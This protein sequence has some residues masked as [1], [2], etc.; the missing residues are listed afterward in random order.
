MRLP[1]PGRRGRPVAPLA[2]TLLLIAVAA[3]LSPRQQGRTPGA[4]PRALAARHLLDGELRLPAG[5]G[6]PASHAVGR[7]LYDGHAAEWIESRRG[8]RHLLRGPTV[9]VPLED[10][11][12]LRITL[13]T[14]AE[15][16]LVTLPPFDDDHFRNKN[17]QWSSPVALA[18]TF[19]TYVFRPA[20]L[21]HHWKGFERL[22]LKRVV[23]EARGGD[24]ARMEVES[25]LLLTFDDLFARESHGVD[26]LA[27]HGEVRRTLYFPS[28]GHAALALPGGGT[29]RIAL[30]NRSRK[31]PLRYVVRIPERGDAPILDVTVPP[32]AGF[33]S[34]EARIDAAA[35][36]KLSLRIEASSAGP[37]VA[38]VGEPVLLGPER[39]RRPNVVVYLVDTWRA[40]R[41]G[42]Y[43][44]PTPLSPH[45]DR[46]SRR[47][48]LFETAR[49][50]SPWTKPS[51]PSLFT[52][53]YADTHRTGTRSYADMLPD[54]IVTLAEHLRDDGYVT[55]SFCAS[56]LGAQL[57]RLEQGFDEV[58]TPTWFQPRQA[59]SRTLIG[60]DTL[61]D[62]L[63]PWLARHRDERFFVYV[64]SLDAH[65]P[66]ENAASDMPGYPGGVR[67][68]DAEIG[69]LTAQ[70]AALG[71]AE[72][73]LLVVTSDHGESEGEHGMRG[74]GR[75]IYDEIVR[76]PLLVSGAGTRPALRRGNGE[77]VD[78]MP[79][80]LET[81]G[82]E[83]PAEVQGRSLRSGGP[84][85]R[86][87]SSRLFYIWE[88]EKPHR[89]TL[90]EGSTK[91][92]WTP[93]TSRFELYDLA[94]DPAERRDLYGDGDDPR[95]EAM[96][97]A[98]MAQVAAQE[99]AALRLAT[100]EGE[101]PDL[102]DQ[103]DLELLRS[104][105]YVK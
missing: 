7:E 77:L 31:L 66:W 58:Y 76:I 52:G 68:N 60:A 81:A 23:L 35:S 72:D 27:L 98:V 63:L 46:L 69:R 30:G 33:R 64:H 91:I 49:S 26:E 93:A 53:L 34:Y 44:D 83:V 21:L 25:V 37:T 50:Q 39:R 10:V 9:G 104:L 38:L 59:G 67:F 8:D 82:L 86:S 100:P 105:G 13:R 3:G 41:I 18:G 79:T 4:A 65:H 97:A 48:W 12:E 14:G 95:A 43:G 17:F 45:T 20:S 6:A 101:T 47:S 40:D 28:P 73:T 94:T 29:L 85:E 62:A 102:V 103:G 74:H 24:E 75:D 78:V 1:L 11:S 22:D 61:S 2:T 88:P 80:I 71:L 89:Y 90:V 92:I 84:L 70:L 36:A 55:A 56:A 16:F 42:A 87:F 99:R 57:S 96:R 32:D 15:S 19:H 51:I 54:D 5:G